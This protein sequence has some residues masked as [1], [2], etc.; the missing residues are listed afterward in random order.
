[1]EGAR[2][3]GGGRRRWRWGWVVGALIAVL[4]ATAATSRNSPRNPLSGITS[5][6]CQCTVIFS[7]LPSFAK[8]RSW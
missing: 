1:M 5:K 8:I 3:G 7:P 2:N 6:L 4:L